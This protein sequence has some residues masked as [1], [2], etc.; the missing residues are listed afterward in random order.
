MDSSPLGPGGWDQKES[1]AFHVLV[2]ILRF[3]RQ[4]RRD[5]EASVCES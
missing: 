3:A 1:W 4:P 5:P 2:D